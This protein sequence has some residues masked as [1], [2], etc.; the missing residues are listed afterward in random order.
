HLVDSSQLQCELWEYQR[1]TVAW[2]IAREQAELEGVGVHGGVLAEEMGLGKTVE[3][4]ALI[5]SHMDPSSDPPHEW[6]EGG[7]HPLFPG[8]LR[9]RPAVNS[10]CGSC[11]RRPLA[12]E[13]MHFSRAAGRA[14]CQW[15]F[16]PQLPRRERGEVAAGPSRPRVC[17]EGSKAD[18]LTQPRSASCSSLHPP[19]VAPHTASSPPGSSHSPPRPSSGFKIRVKRPR[20]DGQFDEE[21]LAR[22]GC[23]LIVTPAS[24]LSQWLQELQRHSPALAART[25]VYSGMREL[26]KQ[27]GVEGLMRAMEKAVV[28]LTTYKVLKSEVWYEGA[29]EASPKHSDRLRVEKRYALPRSPLLERT[30]WRVAIDEA[31]M[32]QTKRLLSGGTPSMLAAMTGRV[33]ALHRWCVT[34]TPL[35]PERGV[36]DGFQ[37]LRFLKCTHPLATDATSFLA[38]TRREE[39]GP[40]LGLLHSLMRRTSKTLVAAQL[41]M[42]PPQQHSI[43][44]SISC[45]ERAWA[46]RDASEMGIPLEQLPPPRHPEVLQEPLAKKPRAANE[47]GSPVCTHFELQRA[48]THVQLSRSWTGLGRS[49]AQIETGTTV[50]PLEL[51]QRCAELIQRKKQLAEL[52]HSP[53]FPPA[54]ELAEK[55]NE[56]GSLHTAL[57]ALGHPDEREHAVGAYERVLRV[58][59]WGVAETKSAGDQVDN[60]PETLRRWWAEQCHALFRLLCLHHDSGRGDAAFFTRAELD[61]AEEEYLRDTKLARRARHFELRTHR[62]TAVLPQLLQLASL[63]AAVILGPPPQSL[64][65]SLLDR[66][67]GELDEPAVSC[68]ELLA[69]SGEANLE[70]LSSTLDSVSR[71]GTGRPPIGWLAKHGLAPLRTWLARVEQMLVRARADARASLEAA[72]EEA[73]MTSSP[74]ASLPTGAREVEHSPA[75]GTRVSRAPERRGGGGVVDFWDVA[76]VE[77]GNLRWLGRGWLTCG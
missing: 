51:M 59:E 23:T 35:S 10:V 13:T 44:L 40:L 34:G 16:L 54:A 9:P 29:A 17:F 72:E 38:A 3:I 74:R 68:V 49:E 62:L 5:L 46:A 26:G 69:A 65:F 2:A 39:S 27:H 77:E 53:N 67:E 37:L 50:A 25:V 33:A 57:A 7:T 42:L 73:G 52:A 61:K 47:D 76:Q 71:G 66:P 36:V 45:A 58:F 15:C 14:C 55:L 11:G 4:M 20:P 8:E 24:I 12:Q 18:R 41:G 1:Q 30:F 75:D 21:R 60:A 22:V 63:W 43:Q 48:F 70:L 64:D 6:S 19:P 31:Q 56:K 28:V 32:V